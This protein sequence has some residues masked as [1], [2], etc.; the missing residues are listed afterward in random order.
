MTVAGSNDRSF[1]QP[2]ILL[3]AEL[4]NDPGHFEERLAAREVASSLPFGERAKSLGPTSLKTDILGALM[5]ASDFFRVS[6]RYRNVLVI[7]PDI[8]QDAPA[9]DL[10]RLGRKHFRRS[11]EGRK[12]AFFPTS[13]LS[14]CMH[15]VDGAGKHMEYWQTLRDFWVAVAHSLY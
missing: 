10:D 13:R 3:Y 1:A 11:D 8:R 6:P 4:S 2:Y 14:K 15:W 7:F 5:V 9:L 12:R